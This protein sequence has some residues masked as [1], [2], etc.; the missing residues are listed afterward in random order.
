AGGAPDAAGYTSLSS[1]E[2][3]DP[4]TGAWTASGSLNAARQAH[5]ATLLPVGTVLVAGGANVGYFSA[6]AEIYD[7]VTGAWRP[8]G[9]L[10]SARGIHSATLLP[11]GK[12]LA[13]GGN[14]NDSGNPSIVTLSSAEVYN[15]ANETW[16]ATGSLNASRTTHTATLLPSG[17]VLVA[18]GY[19]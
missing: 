9:A 7:P 5:S 18:G 14:H 11:D 2:V 16:T 13:V 15:P 19:N 3:Y 12:V 4:A 8:T 6:S 10:L 1:A 17:K